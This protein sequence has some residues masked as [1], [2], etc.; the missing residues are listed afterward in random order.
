MRDARK[1][2]QMGLRMPP[3]LRAWIEEQ[4]ERNHCSLNSEVVRRLDEQRRAQEG[5]R[6]DAR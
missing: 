3:E 4:A 5:G 1:M 6:N 2:P